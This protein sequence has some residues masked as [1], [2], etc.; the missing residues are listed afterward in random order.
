MTPEQREAAR[1]AAII[2]K[3]GERYHVVFGHRYYFWLGA[4]CDPK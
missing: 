2:A 4:D 1:R 3:Y